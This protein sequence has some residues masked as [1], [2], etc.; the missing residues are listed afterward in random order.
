MALKIHL[1][2]INDIKNIGV[3]DTQPLVMG[4]GITYAAGKIGNAIKF[5]NSCASC[6]HMPG[7]KL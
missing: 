2:L 6:V 5:P 7:L 1:P 3:S 4:T